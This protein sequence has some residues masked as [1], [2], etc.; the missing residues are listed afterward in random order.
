M[1]SKDSGEIIA[2]EQDYGPLVYGSK[3]FVITHGKGAL[4]YTKDGRELLDFVAGHGVGN[5]G[6][7]HPKVVKAIQ[8]QASNITVYTA[9]FQTS[10][11][12]SSL[13]S[14]Q[15]LRLENCQIPFSLIAVLKPL[16][17]RSKLR[18]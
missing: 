18:L 9:L 4:L 7:A 5:I 14:S 2:Q 13:R 15:K 17:R 11:V 12:V 6:H 16:K 10:N 1:D 8:E 3:D